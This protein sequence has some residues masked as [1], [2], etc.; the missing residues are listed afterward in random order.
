MQRSG[1]HHRVKVELFVLLE[2]FH[3]HWKTAG[4]FLTVKKPMESSMLS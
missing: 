2:L 4:G 1:A 3:R